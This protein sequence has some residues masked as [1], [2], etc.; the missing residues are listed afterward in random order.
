MDRTILTIV[1]AVA[2]IGALAAATLAVGYRATDEPV[3]EPTA[4]AHAVDP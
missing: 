3:A 1:A 2:G 4:H